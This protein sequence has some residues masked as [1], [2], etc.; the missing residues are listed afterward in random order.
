MREAIEKGAF[1]AAHFRSGLA[2]NLIYFFLAVVFFG[3]M[4]ESARS[5]G[6]LV[7]ME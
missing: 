7:K 2:L 6:L 3:W 1:S 4:F 5:R